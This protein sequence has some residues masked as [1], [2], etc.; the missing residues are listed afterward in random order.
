M[1]N[2]IGDDK[3]VMPEG[4]RQPELKAGERLG[5]YEII[6][7]LG[8]GGMGQVYLARHSMM[9]TTHAVKILPSEYAE[10]SGFVDRFRA[11]VQV[12]AKLQHPGI[13]RVTH[14]DVDN[15]RYY[16][17]MEFVGDAEGS[18]DL[19]QLL[20][21]APEHRL[22][23]EQVAALAIQI[24]EAVAYAHSHG[25]IHRDLKPSNVLVCATT[26]YTKDTKERINS[27]AQC[28]VPSASVKITDFGLAKMV[29]A[30][31]VQSVI[32]ASMAQASISD[33]P[34]VGGA[35][36]SSTG[37]STKSILGTYEYMSPEQREGCDAGE[38]SDIYAIGVMLYRMLTGKRIMGFPKPPS[39]IVKGFDPKWDDLI[40]ECLDEDPKDRPQSMEAVREKLLECGGHQ[41]ATPLSDEETTKDTKHTKET[42]PRINLDGQ[43]NVD[44]A[45][46]S[47]TDEELAAKERKEREKPAVGNVVPKEWQEKVAENGGNNGDG[48]AW[49]LE[50]YL[51]GKDLVPALEKLGKLNG[52]DVKAQWGELNP[53]MQRMDLGNVLRGMIRRGER[54]EV[55]EIATWNPEDRVKLSYTKKR[56]HFIRPLIEDLKAD[57]VFEIDCEAGTFRMSR[58]QFEDVFSNIPQ[59]VSWEREG[60]YHSAQ[61]P[62][63][64]MRFLIG[65]ESEVLVGHKASAV[66]P[67]S[68]EPMPTDTEFP[69]PS[70]VSY[71]AV[72]DAD[73][74]VVCSKRNSFTWVVVLICMIF[75]GLWLYAMSSCFP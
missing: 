63:K 18:S 75:L 51:N 7:L 36:S 57:E 70:L 44:G 2:S 48:L 28:L 39:R 31:W 4:G 37:T 50:K 71:A 30:E 56:L 32:Q 33:M 72:E 53:G 26:K 42:E 19:E 20:S 58:A 54:V 47:V 64:A 74:I 17:V 46:C 9:R 45:S 66:D 35:T 8:R 15:G 11:E 6:K 65:E 14:A 40:I 13:V 69:I 61:P 73:D 25:V 49:A 24:C 3:T 60:E 29:G 67:N 16:L 22:P 23:P 1:D 62:Q 10:R 27:S 12:M 21:T 59:T 55:P 68:S 43:G 38:R 41:R 34:T 5:Q 52:I